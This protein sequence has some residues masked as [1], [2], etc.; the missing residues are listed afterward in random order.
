LLLQLVKRNILFQCMESIGIYSD[1]RR[2]R[3]SW[4]LGGERRD[5]ALE[6]GKCVEFTEDGAFRPRSGAGGARAGDSGSLEEIEEIVVR[7]RKHL[8]EEAW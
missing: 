2:W 4:A 1:T 3:T 5:F 8:S 7:D 6:D